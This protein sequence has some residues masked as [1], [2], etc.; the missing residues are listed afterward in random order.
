MSKV[1]DFAAQEQADIAALNTKLDSIAS[2]VTALDALI[3]QLQSTIGGLSAEDQ[4]ALGSV[5]SASTALVAKANGIST[6]A[7]PVPLPEPSL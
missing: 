3:V 5:A 1:T 7:P 6:D 2:G 4:A